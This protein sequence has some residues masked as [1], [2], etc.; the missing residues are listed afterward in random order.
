[1]GFTVFCC[2]Q[3]LPALYL[4]RHPH[5][6]V[7]HPS[8][9]CGQGIFYC[10]NPRLERRF[11]K[12]WATRKVAHD[13][14]VLIFFIFL[15]LSIEVADVAFGHA[16]QVG[17]R[18]YCFDIYGDSS[19]CEDLKRGSASH[20][21]WCST[22]IRVYR[23]NLPR[24][25]PLDIMK[26]RTTADVIDP[27][28]LGQTP[29]LQRNGQSVAFVKLLNTWLRCALQVRHILPGLGAALLMGAML[30]ASVLR[31]AWYISHRAGLQL[32]LRILR[33]VQLPRQRSGHVLL[34]RLMHGPGCGTLP[35][36]MVC[37]RLWLGLLRWAEL[38]Q[39]GPVLQ[40][41]QS[42]LAGQAGGPS[43][44]GAFG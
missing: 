27:Q 9:L 18:D 40:G 13:K 36:S 17:T 5:H 42:E 22:C 32:L 43:A 38:R 25:L 2:A 19:M 3:N 8:G 33:C 41:R 16:P 14:A 30:A 37:N 44:R 24:L 28:G 4:L 21:S 34:S 1:M 26:P 15:V 29:P 39:A 35:A 7:V 11:Q 20:M 23:A 6:H 10:R 12:R 31:P